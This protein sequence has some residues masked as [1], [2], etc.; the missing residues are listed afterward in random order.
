MFESEVDTYNFPHKTKKNGTSVNM[1]KPKTKMHICSTVT[2]LRKNCTFAT[3]TS[4]WEHL[5]R[6]SSIEDT[7]KAVHMFP[8]STH[9]QGC[10]TQPVGQAWGRKTKCIHLGM[11]PS[12]KAE[13]KAIAYLLYPSSKGMA[14][15][16]LKFGIGL[17]I[18]AHRPRAARCRG[19][20][21]WRW[22][23]GCR[24]S[25]STNESFHRP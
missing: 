6:T 20:H 14:P 22:R 4:A 5:M 25:K 1:L 3:C 15:K 16:D 11:L 10:I 8:R 7:W 19:D 12:K 13:Y 21:R 23:R 17:I 9:V 18:L 24:W 2:S